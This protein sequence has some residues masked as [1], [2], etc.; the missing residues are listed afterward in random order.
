MNTIFAHINYITMIMGNDQSKQQIIRE[1]D[2]FLTMTPETDN[3]TLMKQFAYIK[4][5]IDTELGYETGTQNE[6]NTQA[7]NLMDAYSNK[8]IR[9]FFPEKGKPKPVI[10]KFKVLSRLQDRVNQVRNLIQEN[11]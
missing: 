3:D 5:K 9:F 10:D 7:F 6:V 2:K 4:A 11:F 1:I 8:D